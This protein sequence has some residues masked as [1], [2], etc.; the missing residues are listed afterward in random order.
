MVPDPNV[1]AG[2]R[3]VDG[4]LGTEGRFVQTV[5]ELLTYDYTEMN[6]MLS[7]FLDA[8]ADDYFQNLKEAI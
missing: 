5:D 2:I 7:T 3:D 4:E 1:E 8:I 6:R